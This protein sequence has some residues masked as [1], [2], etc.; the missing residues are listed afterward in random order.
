MKQKKLTPINPRNFFQKVTTY[1]KP[2]LVL[3]VLF[4]IGSAMFLPRL[5]FDTSIEAFIDNKNPV[6]VYRD[7]VKATFGMIKAYS[8][9]KASNS[10][11][12]SAIRW[13]ISRASIPRKS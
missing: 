13:F 10:L 1:Y 5:T 8:M 7:K 3:S 11:P 6:L 2:I 12:N 9:S 4:I